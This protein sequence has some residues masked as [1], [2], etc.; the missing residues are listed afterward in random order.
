MEVIPDIKNS[1]GYINVN[2]ALDEIFGASAVLEK[3]EEIGKGEEDA[4]FR[5]D[6]RM[7]LKY[8]NVNFV[9]WIGDTIT[10]GMMNAGSIGGRFSIMIPEY[11]LPNAKP[12]SGWAWNPLG[13]GKLFTE[14]EDEFPKHSEIWDLLRYE[15][16]GND[17][18]SIKK[19]LQILKDYLNEQIRLENEEKDRNSFGF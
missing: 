19:S 12:L 13:N 10:Q 2:Q 6:F 8:R 3:Y 16:H 14:F 4:E 17:L 18:K 15:G 11:L 7:V 1:I 5:N 9:V